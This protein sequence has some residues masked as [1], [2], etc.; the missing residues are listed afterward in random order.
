MFTRSWISCP[1][2]DSSQRVWDAKDD[3]DCAECALPIRIRVSQ[4][5]QED[6]IR[7]YYRDLN[8]HD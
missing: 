7:Q 2:C 1:F 8:A 4:S 5:K 6:A 3:V